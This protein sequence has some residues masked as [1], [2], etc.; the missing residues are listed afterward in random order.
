MKELVGSSLLVSEYNHPL[1][2]SRLVGGFAQPTPLEE[3]GKVDK[4]LNKALDSYMLTSTAESQGHDEVQDALRFQSRLAD[5]TVFDSSA[6]KSIMSKATVPDDDSL[7]KTTLIL[8]QE[9]PSQDTSLLQIVL[10]N[11]VFWFVCVLFPNV[12]LHTVSTDQTNTIGHN[13]R[14][15]TWPTLIPTQH[16]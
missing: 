11:N 1:S 8:G 3:S 9:D 2:S 15:L 5:G 16:Q 12:F 6:E 4:L 14:M 10:L 7:A 13:D